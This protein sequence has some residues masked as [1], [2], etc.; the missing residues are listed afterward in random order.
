M[1]RYKKNFDY[2]KIQTYVFAAI[3][4]VIFGTGTYLFI[5]YG[6]LSSSKTNNFLIKNN[7]YSF[8][9]RAPKNWIAQKDINYSDEAVSRILASCRNNNQ[10]TYNNYEI[11]AFRFESQNYPQDFGK[12]GHYEDGLPSGAI[13]N[14]SIFC[15]PNDAKNQLADYSYGSLE[16]G[17]ERVLSGILDLAGFGATKYLSLVHKDFQYRISEYV[18]ISSADKNKEEELR[19]YY[20]SA[21][22]EI[23][24]SVRFIK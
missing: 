3:I 11:G 7:Y 19:Q 20:S 12:M 6:N 22:K 17:G 9:L 2:K 4:L 18:Y 15:V 10:N 1:A 23:A 16:I 8:Q 14:I 21:L 24:A 5:K 13:L